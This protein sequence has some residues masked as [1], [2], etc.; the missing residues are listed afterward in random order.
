MLMM[1]KSVKKEKG[2]IS[3]R[4][5]EERMELTWRIQ[6]NVGQTMKKYL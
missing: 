1:R 4:E 2:K 6:K 5:R 3:Q